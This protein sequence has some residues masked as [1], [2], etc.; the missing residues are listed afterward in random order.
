MENM[1]K[2]LIMAAGILLSLILISLVVWFYND[3]VDFENLKEDSKATDQALEFNQKYDAYIRDDLYG[4]EVVSAANQIVDYN[5]RFTTESG[6]QEIEIEVVLSKEKAILD[7]Q[8]FMPGNYDEKGILKA[9]SDLEKELKK[10]TDR[11]YADGKTIDYFITLRTNELQSFINRFGESNVPN[12]STRMAYQA[13]KDEMTFFKRKLFDCTNVEYSSTN[14]RIIK[15]V[16]T[17]KD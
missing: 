13:L 4:S 1:S 11:V 17:E 7:A 15:M 6:F 10:Y 14:G 8:Y 9:Y 16:F 5:K 2:A 3:I 12:E